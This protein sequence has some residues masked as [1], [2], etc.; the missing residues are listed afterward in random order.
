MRSRTERKGN[1]RGDS[2]WAWRGEVGAGEC[3]RGS[4]RVDAKASHGR[5]AGGGLNENKNTPR[6][7]KAEGNLDVSIG[8]E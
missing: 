3:E 6:T 8:Y 5:M 2:V 1:S 7:D 4:G